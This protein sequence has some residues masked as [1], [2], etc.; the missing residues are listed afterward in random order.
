MTPLWRLGNYLAMDPTPLRLGL[1]INNTR[2]IETTLRLVV[3]LWGVAEYAALSNKRWQ[4][5]LSPRGRRCARRA[6]G[7][8]T[9]RKRTRRSGRGFKCSRCSM[10]A[11][12]PVINRCR[13]LPRRYTRSA[14]FSEK[15][16][17]LEVADRKTYAVFGQAC[18]RYQL[19][20]SSCLQFAVSLS[21]SVSS[22]RP[23]V[24][25]RAIPV[26]GSPFVVTSVAQR[27]IGKPSIGAA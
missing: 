20:D 18:V 21:G 8:R 6:A 25:Y 27:R 4:I 2:P 17:R 5:A 22:S 14:T 7:S 15:P 12:I 19:F 10:L 11:S 16:L 9:S 26:V 13:C 24:M 1:L 3:E 23:F